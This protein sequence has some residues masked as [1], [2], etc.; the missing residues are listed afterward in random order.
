MNVTARLDKSYNKYR[1]KIHFV[2]SPK[3]LPVKIKKVI[4]YVCACRWFHQWFNFTDGITNDA[5]AVKEL[6]DFG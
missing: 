3:K 2:T 5:K 1:E 6:R 4:I